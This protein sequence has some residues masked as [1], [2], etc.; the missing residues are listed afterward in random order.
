MGMWDFKPWDNDSAADWYGDF[1]DSTNLR[2]H[3]LEGI[4]QDPIDDA[5]TVRAAAS[6]F[7]ML[8]RVYVWPIDHLDEDLELA[9]SQLKKTLECEENKEVPEL[10]EIIQS[11]INELESRVQKKAPDS[12]AQSKPWWKIW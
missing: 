3:W 2:K 1:M 6:V 5:D 11:E 7:I 8:G 12:K 10:I 9:I 4:K